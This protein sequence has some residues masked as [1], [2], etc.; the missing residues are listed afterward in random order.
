MRNRIVI[1]GIAMALL[2]S[3]LV[4]T[5]DA[6]WRWR[7]RCR[8]SCATSC[9]HSCSSTCQ[10]GYCGST[11]KTDVAT[12]GPTRQEMYYRGTPPTAPQPSAPAVQTPP[13][14]TPPT[15]DEL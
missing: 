12:T 9:C 4:D 11:C 2:T 7:R 6:A 8:T 10:T 5:S 13:Q 15:S 3:V 14:P 1:A